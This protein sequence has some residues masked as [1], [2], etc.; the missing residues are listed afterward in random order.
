MTKIVCSSPEDRWEGGLHVA[1]VSRDRRR[2]ARL[3][4]VRGLEFSLLFFTFD[5]HLARQWFLRVFHVHRERF[6]CLIVASLAWVRGFEG[7]IVLDERS[8]L[9]LGS[10][11]WDLRVLL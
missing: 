2:W 8:S 4:I 9:R 7:L 1:K 11:V 10:T 3:G 5:W 6:K